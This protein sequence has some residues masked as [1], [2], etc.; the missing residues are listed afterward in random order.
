MHFVGTKVPEK[1]SKLLSCIQ[2]ATKLCVHFDFF[3]RQDSIVVVSEIV[4]DRMR[5]F[6]IEIFPQSLLAKVNKIQNQINGFDE[7]R[8]KKL[9]RPERPKSV[10]R[11]LLAGRLSMYGSEKQMTKR[12]FKG[13]STSKVRGI[14]N[15]V[16]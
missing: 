5:R 8:R 9:D 4:E 14:H 6:L 7:I 1:L 3:D 15:K 11:I 12:K 2:E 16:R 10:P 13:R